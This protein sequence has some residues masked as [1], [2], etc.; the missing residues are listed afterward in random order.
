MSREP[1]KKA[2]QEAKKFKTKNHQILTNLLLF[3]TLNQRALEPK[4]PKCFRGLCL[5]LLNGQVSPTTIHPLT[6]PPIH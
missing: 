6:I 1:N 2:S 5:K 4:K 3:L